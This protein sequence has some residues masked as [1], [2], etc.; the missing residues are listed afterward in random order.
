MLTMSTS[1][2]AL[3]PCPDKP[4]CVSSLATNNRQWIE[5]VEFSST[6]DIAFQQLKQI[7]L[8]RPRHTIVKEEGGYLRIEARSFLFH[9]IDD[10]E[11]Q[12][13][14]DGNAIDVRSGSRSG[15]SDFGVNRRRI[16]AIRQQFNAS[17]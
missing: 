11:F 7:V 14:A 17:R 16:E 9:F 13:T 2:P 6:P 4:N 10:I 12:L 5:P 8:D 1:A 3:A 15:Y